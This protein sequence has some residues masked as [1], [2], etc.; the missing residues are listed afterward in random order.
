[1]LY[2]IKGL[3]EEAKENAKGA[4]WW[5]P[6]AHLIPISLLSAGVFNWYSPH[7]WKGPK[8]SDVYISNGF[9]EFQKFCNENNGKC[10]DIRSPFIFVSNN[11]GILQIE[12]EPFPAI[13]DCLYDKVAIGGSNRHLS[14]IQSEIKYFKSFDLARKLHLVLL[15]VKIDGRYVVEEKNRITAIVNTTL[16]D[17]GKSHL[18]KGKFI[19]PSLR[20]HDDF[21]TNILL[22]F[23]VFVCF[24]LFVRG[25]I[26]TAAEIIRRKF[27]V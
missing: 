18:I 17:H 23:W 8:P 1:M 24:W 10:G 21:M 5:M 15:S 22:V 3:I 27:I 25:V 6:F 14:N 20:F 9:F 4:K 11:E 7:F 19:N 26:F 12:C 13:N 16:G 2:I